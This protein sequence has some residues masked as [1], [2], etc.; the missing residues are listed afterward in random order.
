MNIFGGHNIYIPN[1][2]RELF[3]RYCLTRAEGSKNDPEDSPF[4]RMVD[5]WFLGLNV[6]AHLDLNPRDLEKK[7]SYNAIEGN[8]FG[9]DSYR[10]DLIVLFCIAK[11]GS[12]D[13]IEKPSEML[14]LAN[15]Y[16][17]AGVYYITQELEKVRARDEPLDYLCN[18]CADEILK[19]NSK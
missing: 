9:N 15:S 5:L 16:A 18:L 11:T 4:P 19:A 8:V 1:N 17:L 2:L 6:A 12:I 13:C 14:R 10:S 3:A 7:D